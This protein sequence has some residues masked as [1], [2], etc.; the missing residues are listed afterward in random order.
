L[1]D[2]KFENKFANSKNKVDIILNRDYYNN[3]K[4][5]VDKKQSILNGKDSLRTAIL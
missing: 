1:T 4:L 3:R 2:F 5:K